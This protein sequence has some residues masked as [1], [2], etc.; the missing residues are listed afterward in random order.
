MRDKGDRLDIDDNKQS[1][2]LTDGLMIIR[3]LFGFTGDALTSGFHSAF[4]VGAGFALAGALTAL[5]IVPTVRRPA[6]APAG[7]PAPSEA[8]S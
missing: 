1:D 6:P 8:G 3:Y 5:V 4:M 2:A 7:E